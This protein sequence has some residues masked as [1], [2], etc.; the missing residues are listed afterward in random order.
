MGLIR[1]RPAIARLGRAE[2]GGPTSDD[3]ARARAV[4]D[5][6]A[7]LNVYGPAPIVRD[8][9]Q[10]AA[11]DRY[12]D[13][14]SSR[15]R[16]A[17]AKLIREPEQQVVVGAGSSELIHAL[18]LCLIRQGDRAV[19]PPHTF[20]EYARAVVIAGGTVV[21]ANARQWHSSPETA[22]ERFIQAV[23]SSRSRM[24][25]LCVPE[26]PTGRSW[27]AAAIRRVADVCESVGCLL[28][29]DQA[30]DAFTATPLG[31]PVLR[32]HAAVAHL[33]SLTKAHGMPG[34]RAGFIVADQTICDA[35]AHAR[36]AWSVSAQSQAAI[37][38]SCDVTAIAHATRT[39]HLLRQ[40][41]RELVTTLRDG[42]WNVWASDTHYFLVEV[43]DAAVFR[44]GL[45]ARHAMRVRACG[46]FALPAWIRIASRTPED[47]QRLLD[48]LL[49]MTPPPPAT[50][51]DQQQ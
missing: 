5:F 19:V 17:V 43:G 37:T 35:L 9:I 10:S 40:H 18:C 6:S 46:T 26:N 22:A 44:D 12:P 23:K 33:C 11:I 16:S 41:A 49:R 28:V 2:H 21:E 4:Y 30:Y 36:P 1:V 42:A 50:S 24:A 34:T 25:F 13:P 20:A 14:T 48:V 45:L 27:S 38:A 8:A 31:V 32:G 29:L 7:P 3:A 47:N 39:I 51:N 15:A